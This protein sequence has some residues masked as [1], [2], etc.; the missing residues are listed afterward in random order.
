MATDQEIMELVTRIVGVEESARDVKRLEQAIAD[1]AKVVRDLDA[2]L[3]AGRISQAAF[4]QAVKSSG[5]AILDNT[6]KLKAAE[7]QLER[8]MDEAGKGAGVAGYKMMQFGQTIDDLQYVGEQG[9]RPVINNI[10]QISPAL[11]IAMI[12]IQTVGIPA[13]KALMEAMDP[14]PV[15]DLN[16]S[17]KD[18]GDRI[19][20]LE[21][22]KV[23]L[24]VETEELERAKEKQDELLAGQRA[25]NGLLG[26][27]TQNEKESGRAIDNAIIETPGGQEAFDAAKNLFI[28]EDIENNKEYIDTKKAMDAQVA[29]RK[30][31]KERIAANLSPDDV[32]AAEHDLEKAEEEIRALGKQFKDRLEEIRAD[33][34]AKFGKLYLDATQGKGLKQVQSQEELAR[35]MKGAGD[36]GEQIS[37]IIGGSSPA[38]MAKQARDEAESKLIQEANAELARQKAAKQ[39]SATE[40]KKIIDAS[41]K[42]DEDAATA[43]WAAHNKQVSA[44]QTQVDATARPFVAGSM[45]KSI[46]TAIKGGMEGGIVREKTVLGLQNRGVDP[47]LVEEVADKVIN[48]IREA[49]KAEG[50]K[51]APLPLNKPRTTKMR[52]KTIEQRIAAA[53]AQNAA[54]KTAWKKELAARK[55]ARAAA[56]MPKVK[57][58]DM[59]ARDPN[60]K[61]APERMGPPAPPE[62]HFDPFVNLLGTQAQQ[63]G[64]VIQN[65]TTL[66]N[67]IISVEEQLNVN[68]RL[69]NVFN[70]RQRTLQMR[71]R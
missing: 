32:A 8:Y 49:L 17:L 11:G 1:E 31:A 52:P 63:T 56:R 48:E 58:R 28:N 14:K 6:A 33:S 40:N 9:L 53:K 65:Q 3:K 21:D 44:H 64:V 55:A 15:K 50:D 16:G 39:K 68:A 20:E 25:L 10:M 2:D 36:V 59:T 18:I 30:D 61:D 70:Q 42:L 41:N 4:D 23:L 47:A 34:E 66:S 71:M 24:Q 46:A 35:Y 27:Q 37:E 13:F 5:Q 26:T 60:H 67:R 12:A 19:K 45:G 43:A 62:G 38:D 54:R 69:N 57:R 7:A 22:K 51:A 29:R